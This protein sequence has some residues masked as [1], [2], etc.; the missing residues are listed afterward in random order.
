MFNCEIR[1]LVSIYP[2]GG[3]QAKRL[4][5]LAKVEDVRMNL[6]TLPRVGDVIAVPEIFGLPP[7]NSLEFF[8]K[9]INVVSYEDHHILDIVPLSMLSC[10]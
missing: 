1:V 2:G 5:D 7:A 4:L 9:V 8:G 10:H 6:Q 3:R